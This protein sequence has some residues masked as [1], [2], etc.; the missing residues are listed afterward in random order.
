MDMNSLSTK[1]IRRMKNLGAGRKDY[2][3]GAVKR[4][5]DKIL[6]IGCSHGWA[7]DALTGKANEL[8]GVDMN[9]EIL[10]QAAVIYPHIKFVYQN[11]N[12]LPFGDKEFDIVILSDVIEHVGDEN[13]PLVI[14]EA[15]RV[16]KEDGLLVFTAPYAGILAWADPMDFKRRFPGIY[17]LYMRIS[18]YA[19]GTPVEIGHKH[20]SCKEIQQLFAG[21]FHIENIRYCGL[22]TPFF[23][24]ILTLDVRLHILPRWLH[25]ALNRL[26]DW[27]SGISYGKVLS[28]TIRLCAR[29]I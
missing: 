15:Y 18:G 3:A 7:L 5:V 27:E 16:L 24:L 1:T 8:V 11:A 12:T 28:F 25:H 2:V 4:P 9:A 26:G 23:T 22:M 10:R 20:V 19:P 21:K 29:K 13:K 14:D 6:D 17:R